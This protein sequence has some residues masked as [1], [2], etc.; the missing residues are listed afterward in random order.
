MSKKKFWPIVLWFMQ[1]R[2][3]AYIYVP[4]ETH[5]EKVKKLGSFDTPIEALRASNSICSAHKNNYTIELFRPSYV[6]RYT[7]PNH[8]GSKSGIESSIRTI[9]INNDGITDL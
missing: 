5:N 1:A 3:G 6:E 8:L 7:R 4:S 9:A 2:G